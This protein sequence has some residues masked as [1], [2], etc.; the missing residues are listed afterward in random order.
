MRART[1][2]RALLAVAVF[3]ALVVAAVGATVA[4]AVATAKADAAD[5][6]G[7]A[8]EKRGPATANARAGSGAAAS[9]APVVVVT[10][11]ARKEVIPPLLRQRLQ[12]ERALVR[13]MRGH[14]SKELVAGWRD[15]E[16]SALSLW[17]KRRV[18]NVDLGWAVREVLEE[19][20]DSG[21][22]SEQTL[23]GEVGRT[24]YLAQNQAAFVSLLLVALPAGAAFWA[25]LNL[26]SLALSL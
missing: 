7:P 9:A 8:G 19:A 10:G 1:A 22:Y 24:L 11:S 5:Q 16:V 25:S 4:A 15:A 23:A 17:L 20:V 3:L 26:F 2:C 21:A 14:I 12:H 18:G 6:A 13:S